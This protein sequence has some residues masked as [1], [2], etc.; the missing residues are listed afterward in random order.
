[1]IQYSMKV[2][3]EGVA[4]VNPNQTPVIAMDQPLFVIAKHIQWE[5]ADF[6]REEEYVV[7]IGGL[8]VELNHFVENEVRQCI[9]TS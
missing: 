3:Q 8:H 7:M 9:R 6:Y 4:F 5:K 1:M 2:V